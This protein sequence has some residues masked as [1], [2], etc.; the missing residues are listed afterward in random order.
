[1]TLLDP[2][3]TRF[4]RVF[5]HEATTVPFTGPATKAVH[6]NALDYGDSS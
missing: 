5:L 1:M 4:L 2:K 6:E 3:E